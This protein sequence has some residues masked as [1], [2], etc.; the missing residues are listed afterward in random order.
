MIRKGRRDMFRLRGYVKEYEVQESRDRNG[1][2]KKTPV[3][4]GAWYVRTA[5][6]GMHQRLKRIYAAMAVLMSAVFLACGLLDNAGNRNMVNAL[7]YALSCF[8]VVYY[9]IGM[10]AALR[11]GEKAER[12][13]YE[14]SVCR[15]H[16]SAVGIMVLYPVAVVAEVVSIFTAERTISIMTEIIYLFLCVVMIMAA[17][18]VRYL[19]RK[20]PYRKTERKQ[21]A[22]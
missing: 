6:E 19:C 3:Y 8:P 17:A 13:E 10:V 7:A 20:Y 2:I 21:E 5:E 18:L 22:E 9:L 14:M 1:V 4:I 11:L 16:H 12:R 15:M